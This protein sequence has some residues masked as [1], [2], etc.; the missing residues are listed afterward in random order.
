MQALCGIATM[1]C[2]GAGNLGHASEL[3]F[4]RTAGSTLPALLVIQL[5][6]PSSL[7]LLAV[8]FLSLGILVLMFRRSRSG[9]NN[10]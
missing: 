8:D 7:G 4:H 10:R 2:A 5:P 9:A 6:E 1:I 3:A